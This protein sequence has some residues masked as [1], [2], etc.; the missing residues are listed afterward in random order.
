MPQGKLR[1]RVPA[2]GGRR[3]RLRHAHPSPSPRRRGPLKQSKATKILKRCSSEPSLWI[4]RSHRGDADG[5]D[6]KR[7]ISF[8]YETEGV[9]IR[10]QTCTDV[11]ASSPSLMAFSPPS[12]LEVQS[13]FKIWF[14]WFN[15]YCPR[16]WSKWVILKDPIGKIASVVA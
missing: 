13:R 16:V 5:D 10:P 14:F 1:R 9:L 12:G 4:G 2:N 3:S 11:F 7:M 6:H 8:G 15:N